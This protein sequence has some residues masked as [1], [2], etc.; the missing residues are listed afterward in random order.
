[1]SEAETYWAERYGH[2]MGVEHHSKQ[3][4]DITE[5]F[6]LR[7]KYL[8]V[9]DSGAKIAHEIRAAKKIIEVGC[10]TGELSAALKKRCKCEVVGTDLSQ[11]AVLAARDKHPGMRF[12]T[13]NI[14]TDNLEKFGKFD[15]AV[16]SNTL[17]HF[18][19]PYAVI[20]RMFF[21]SSR[22]LFVVPY[23]QPLADGYEDE[24]G[25]G[26]VFRFTKRTFSRYK[27]LDEFMFETKGWQHS[28]K[29]EKPMQY[30]ALIAKDKHG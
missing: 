1:M 28:S 12:E 15:L 18:K 17:E 5:D 16:S 19:N 22:L 26:H 10:G 20:E 2:K 23:N 27:V 25:A 9:A 3:N 14:L 6:M 30:A 13:L 4:A 11:H 29:G 7:L 24:G 8:D 21:L